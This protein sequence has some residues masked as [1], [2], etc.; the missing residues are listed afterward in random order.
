MEELLDTLTTTVNKASLSDSK[1]GNPLQNLF[2]PARNSSI[3]VSGYKIWGLSHGFS[4]I[5]LPNSASVLWCRGFANHRY[6]V[7]AAH[8]HDFYE[9]FNKEI[10]KSRATPNAANASA[11][12]VTLAKAKIDCGRSPSFPKIKVNY[13]NANLSKS[14]KEEL[15]SHPR[16][17]RENMKKGDDMTEMMGFGEEQEGSSDDDIY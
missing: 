14:V 7:T 1:D 9:R 15:R 11:L 2:R 8:V 10:R 16:V 3:Y 5:S 13:L 6:P 17:G 12:K 4:L